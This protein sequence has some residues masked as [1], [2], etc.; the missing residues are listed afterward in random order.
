[1]P[2]ILNGANGVH[3]NE[4]DSNLRGGHGKAQTR[5]LKPL[6]NSGSLN[7]FA[8]RDLTPVIGR[9]F[10]DGLQVTDL[11]KADQQLIKDLA[12]TSKS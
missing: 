12:V 4:Q 1:M 11:V 3:S 8:Y 7:K 10:D 2:S 9:E 5:C 6:V